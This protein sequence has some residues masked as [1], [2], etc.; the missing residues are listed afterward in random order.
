V[1][2]G[3]VVA[4]LQ[5]AGRR[6]DAG[7]V[8]GAGQSV[9]A[10]H[11]SSSG[12]FSSAPRGASTGLWCCPCVKV[13]GWSIFRSRWR[14]GAVPRMRAI[15]RRDRCGAC[16]WCWSGLTWPG[17]VGRRG[18][19]EG[20]GRWPSSKGL[21]GTGWN[22]APQGRPCRG[23]S[24]GQVARRFGG[25]AGCRGGRE[26]WFRAVPGQKHSAAAF[27]ASGVGTKRFGVRAIGL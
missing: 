13:H 15:G 20:T 19:D 2:R 22:R 21:G 27:R 9:T 17:L 12:R 14:K 23:P 8:T 7:T 10:R 26:R 25:F 5:L 6:V 18:G 24:R 11:S 1:A 16:F 4:Y 3:R